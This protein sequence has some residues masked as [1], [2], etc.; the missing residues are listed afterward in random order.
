[1]LAGSRGLEKYE[2]ATGDPKPVGRRARDDVVK[3]RAARAGDARRAGE[4]ARVRNGIRRAALVREFAIVMKDFAW[5]W[6]EIGGWR[7]SQLG[8][9]TD[10]VPGKWK[11]SRW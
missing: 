10:D 8:V 4:V 3:R 7:V 1:M 9:T 6:C 2:G 11:N 5:G